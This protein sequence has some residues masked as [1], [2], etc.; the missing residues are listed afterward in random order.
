MKIIEKDGTT[1]WVG[2]NA[3]DN[4]D[5]IKKAEQNWLWFHLDKFPSSHVIICKNVKEILE[6]DIQYAC[7]LVKDYSKYKFNNIGIVY[8]E[9]KNLT[10][11]TEVGSVTFKSNN[12]TTKIYLNI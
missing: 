10:I 11:G 4:W 1:Y 2:R 6:N 5:I 3:Q 9:I 7:N 8:C 12:K